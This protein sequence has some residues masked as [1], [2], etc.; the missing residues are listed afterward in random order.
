MK[1]KL[2]TNDQDV[3]LRSIATGRSVRDCTDLLNLKFHTAFTESQIRNYKSKNK[4]TSGMNPWQFEDQSK[5]KITTKEQDQWIFEHF[6]GTGNVELTHMF[7]ET[8]GTSLTVQQI[9]SYKNRHHIS[10]G[11][12]GRFTKGHVPV[13][14][15]TKGL[16][17][18]GGNK[19][20]FKKGQLPPTTDPIG[21]E[22]MLAD[23]YVWVKVNNLPKVRK[24]VNWKQK[25]VLIWEQANG[26]VPKDHIVIFLDG[27][28]ENFNLDNLKCISRA[29]NARLN[30]N[31]LRYEN[32]ELT[33]AGVAVAELITTVNKAKRRIGGE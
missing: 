20:S 7:N 11:L 29:T 21:T 31:H 3:Y 2:L 16:F 5:C 22:K 18:A 23:G 9:K 17:N 10:S 12:T 15:G 33:E 8:F 19:T 26:P 4:I 6:S 30:Q 32:K 27:D 13:N 28:R 1:R 24:V 14:K 25:H